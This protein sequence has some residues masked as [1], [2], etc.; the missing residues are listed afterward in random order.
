MTF[1]WPD[2]PFSGTEVDAFVE[3]YKI[4]AEEIIGKFAVEVEKLAVPYRNPAALEKF[5]QYGLIYAAFIVKQRAGNTGPGTDFVLGNS[6]FSNTEAMNTR[7]KRIALVK[8][9]GCSFDPIDMFL[10]WQRNKEKD[11][12]L[13]PRDELSGPD[14]SWKAPITDLINDYNDEEFY[15]PDCGGY[16]AKYNQTPTQRGL[17]S[18]AILG[19][20][21][22][23]QRL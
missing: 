20:I 19:Y 4:V 1:N 22:S 10:A 21:Q 8:Y 7:A 23:K 11:P 3:E 9:F 13:D 5:L 6:P 18:G 12:T 16:E 14:G 15:G 17:L 2:V